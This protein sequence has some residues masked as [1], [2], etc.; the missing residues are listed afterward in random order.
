MNL[1]RF[2]TFRTTYYFPPIDKGQE[3]L[4]GLYTPYGLIAK[5]YWWLFTH[6]SLARL[7]NRV[8]SSDLDFPYDRIVKLMPKGCLISFNMGTPGDEQK[9]SMLGLEK[10]GNRFFAKYSEKSDAIVLSKNE[11]EVLGSLKENNITPNLLDYKDG[12]I[13]IFFR[14]SYVEGDAVTSLSLNQEIVNLAISISRIRIGLGEED[15]L[16]GLSH[17]DFSPWNMLNDN[18]TYR[19]IDWEMAAQRPLGYDLFTFIYKVNRWMKKEGELKKKILENDYL[20]KLYF[21]EWGIDDYMPYFYY[22][23]R[24]HHD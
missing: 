18:G 6:L 9:V 16:I 10:D 11:I 20:L 14:T 4:Y 23:E 21:A 22:F 3:F 12:G 24:N 1:Y 2:R 8:D 5:I 19:L 17:G 15:L 13:Y 7:L